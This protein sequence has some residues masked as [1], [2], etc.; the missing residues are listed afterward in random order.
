MQLCEL[1][2]YTVIAA[3]RIKVE[4]EASACSVWVMGAEHLRCDGEPSRPMACLMLSVTVILKSVVALSWAEWR[5][6]LR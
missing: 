5:G 3:T 2:P 1:H 4:Q 6:E